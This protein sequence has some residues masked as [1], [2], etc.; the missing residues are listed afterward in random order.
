LKPESQGIKSLR[1]LIER[2]PAIAIAQAKQAGG[3]AAFN[4]V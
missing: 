1:D 4:K 2:L 3:F